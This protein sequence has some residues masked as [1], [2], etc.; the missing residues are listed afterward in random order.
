[1]LMENR[2]LNSDKIFCFCHIQS[3]V[4]LVNQPQMFRHTTKNKYRYITD[5]SRNIT[6]VN[7]SIKVLCS[8]RQIICVFGQNISYL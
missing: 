1:M 8:I 2:H 4:G 3:G 6:C 7:I 5:N